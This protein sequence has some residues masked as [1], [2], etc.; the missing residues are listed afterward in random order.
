MAIKKIV[1]NKNWQAHKFG[2]VLEAKNKP[3]RCLARFA[4]K[5]WIIITGPIII[6]PKSCG[7]TK[8]THLILTTLNRI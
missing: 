3:M 1:K 6:K 5:V 4:K 2:K 7:R 8:F